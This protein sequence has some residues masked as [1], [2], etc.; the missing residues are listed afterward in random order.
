[1]KIIGFIKHFSFSLI[2][3]VTALVAVGIFM[4]PEAIVIALILT[5]VELAF[6]FDN[7]IINAKILETMT[8][9]WQRL[10][11]SVGII[12]AV[13]GMRVVFPV[14]I[15]MLTASLGW[16][17]V[18][19][20]AL[21][22]PDIY[23]DKLELAHP[24]IASFGGGFLMMLA[25]YFFIID[26]HEAVWIKRIELPLRRIA[27]WWVPTVL[28]T[29]TMVGLAL[30][31]INQHT[32]ETLQ[33]G[34]IGIGTFL[35]IHLFTDMVGRVA[36]KDKLLGEGKK[37]AQRTGFAAFLTFLYLEM[38]D[39]SFSL[40]GVIG[41]FAVTNQVVLIAVGLGI[42]AVWV[43]SMTVYMVNKGTLASYKYLEH[44][45]HYAVAAL[46]LSMLLSLIHHVPE[47]LIGVVG[48]GLILSSLLASREAMRDKA[49][50]AA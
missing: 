38:L 46:A 8:R 34:L 43:R 48:L 22:K 33:G 44:G 28:A 50:E 40:D 31:P 42:G 26:N 32:H 19:D 16:G 11:L 4:G 2:T 20:L 5:A 9:F 30:L 35:G 15:V 23:A 29:A 45:A 10:F 14:V 25:L 36:G 41:A 47:V 3:T 18:V 21:N 49:L 13:F 12:I 17:E 39:A 27:Q 7:A 1:V 24:M 37:V 6:S